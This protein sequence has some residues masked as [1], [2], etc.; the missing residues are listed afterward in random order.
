MMNPSLIAPKSIALVGASNELS[1][2]GGKALANLLSAK[3]DGEI[4]PVN[5]KEQIV[6]GI[7]C[8]KEITEIPNCDL[9]IIA[10]ASKFVNPTVD[11][12]AEHKG[13]KA[14]IVLSAGFSEV[15]GE[16]IALEQE[17]VQIIN[18]HQA[19]LIGPNCIGV[20]NTH[21]AGVFA[22]PIPKLDPKGCDF[23]SGSGATAV[24]ILETAIQRGLPFASIYSVGNSATIGVEEVL[25][26]WDNNFGENSSKIKLIYIEQVHNPQKFLKHTTSLIKKGCRIAAVKS[27]TSEAGSRAVSSHTGSLAG[28]DSA[29]DALFRKA[30][31]IRCSSRDEL[32]TIGSVLFYKELKGNNIAIITH[33]G[34]PGILCTDALQKNGMNVPK[35]EDEKANELLSK[36]YYGSSVANP[37][38][39]LATGTAEQLGIILDYV[40]NYFDNIDGS[41]VIFGTP[42]LF[43]VT[44]AYN[45]LNNK[46]NT[47]KKPIFPVLPSPVQAA[48]ETEHF[49][50]LGKAIFPDEANLATALAKVYNTNKPAEIEKYNLTKEDIEFRNEIFSKVSTNE[51]LPPDINKNI[52]EYVGLPLVPEY[53]YADKKS[54]DKDVHNFQYPVVMKVIGPVHKSD[55]GGVVLN[56]Q[57]GEEVLSNYD[58]LMQIT[59]ATG[60][61]VQ[62]MV[63]GTE[64]FIG[65][66]KEDDFGHIIFFGLGGIF[67]EVLKD[68]SY[69]LLPINNYE[70]HELIKSIKSYPLIQGIRG[71]K[72][73]DQD[74]LADILMKVSKLSQILPEI[75]EMDINPLIATENSIFSVDMRIKI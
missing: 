33:A 56:I 71:K 69:K 58:K 52:L 12:L 24:F 25:E 53:Y 13:T 23:V 38:D 29:V 27:G 65:L 43:D 36:L 41:I 30:G 45:V 67:V 68:I 34:G 10:I 62:P 32:I 2:P 74:R 57:N 48:K 46:I 49:I 4:Y 35:I 19:S 7:N 42:G 26:Y 66:K 6:Q 18:K 70:A 8:F 15:G 20:M 47:L 16:G 60:V 59:D 44:D 37:I 63:S 39:F 55:V 21:Y 64:L 75:T 17:L 61:L 3:F 11:Y 31:I 28:S 5:P 50:N 51:F 14:F 9:A 73:I 72:G 40:D 1:K 22:G 54:I